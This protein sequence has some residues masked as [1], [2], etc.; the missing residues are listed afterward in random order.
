VLEKLIREVHR[1]SVWQ[2]LA[3]YLVGSWV[4][5]QVADAVTE[6][7]GLPA[8]VPGFALVLLIMGL[9]IVL[10]TAFVQE[11]LPRATAAPERDTDASAPATRLDEPLAAGTDTQRT[12]HRLFTWRNAVLGGVVAFA[13]L[14]VAV[15]GYFAMRVTGFGPAASLAAQGVFD[16]REPIVLADF[17]NATPDA[18]LGRMVT[19]A[20]RIDLHESS[21]VTV[22]PP[23]YVSE[24]L[25]RMSRP[26]DGEVTAEVAREIA[27]RDGIRAVVHG[28][29]GAVGSGYVLTASI[30]DAASGSVFAAFRETA[31]NPDALL[32]TIDRLS[33]RIR[34]KAGES[35]RSIGKGEPLDL[36]TTG[37]LDALRAYTSAV[38]RANVGDR[39]GAVRLLESAIELDPE[40]AMAHRKLAVE[41]GNL[42]M[43]PS[44]VRAAARRAYELR[45]RLTK[46]ERLLAEAHYHQVLGDRERAIDA[47]RQVLEQKPDETV[48]LNNLS[49]LLLSSRSEAEEGLALL[50]RAASSRGANIVP[51][52]NVIGRLWHLRRDADVEPALVRLEQR[53]PDSYVAA[54]AR[55]GVLMLQRQ[56]AASH[57]AAESLQGRFAAQRPAQFSSQLD[58]AANDVGMGRLDEARR[59]LDDAIRVAQQAEQ[60]TWYAT[61]AGRL[62][63]L[64][65]VTMQSPERARAVLQRIEREQP[66][67]TAAV[68]HWEL[69]V[70]VVA[71]SMLGDHA[72]AS[73]AQNALAALTPLAE[74]SEEFDR[75]MDWQRWGTS[76]GAHDGDAA[77]EAINKVMTA[78]FGNCDGRRCW[79]HFEHALALDELGLVDD[80][81]AAYERHMSGLPLSERFWDASI[82]PRSALRLAEIYEQQGNVVKAAEYFARYADM[83]Q[84]ADAELQ[85]RVRAARDRATA[86]LARKG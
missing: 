68:G 86:L 3:I 26:V 45:E 85:P 15:A 60:P 13:L 58:L 30:V 41:L 64:E 36:V 55:V 67:G 24:A 34:E 12:H 84:D 53:Y 27:L 80:A 62:L 10:A 63:W 14:G 73:R 44:R 72:A 29:V 51:Y 33:S 6:S 16:D 65:T 57:A 38:Q 9:P 19:E 11:G 81:A 1:R 4:A 8:W 74:R 35:L 28:E 18:T 76:I 70:I 75:L 79:G 39:E 56:W 2:V 21:A 69:A 52:S 43:S 46:S 83:W 59:H 71:A 61:A 17:A 7:A 54:R 50:Q 5:L 47:L 82:T 40:F 42:N 48:A 49:N 20:L 22:V 37:S 66:F 32:P 23:A 78:E 77:R 25:R 31:P